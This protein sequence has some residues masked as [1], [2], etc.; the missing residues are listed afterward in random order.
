[1]ITALGTWLTHN[2]VGSDSFESKTSPPPRPV[3]HWPLY[4]SWE[5]TLTYGSVVNVQWL[6]CHEL[7]HQRRLTDASGTQHGYAERLGDAWAAGTTGL[8]GRRQRRAGTGPSRT[9][10]GAAAA[11]SAT[12]TSTDSATTAD[13]DHRVVGGRQVFRAERN[14]TNFNVIILRGD[15]IYVVRDNNQ[16]RKPFYKKK[17]TLHSNWHIWN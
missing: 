8:S 2:S 14:R 9:R 10:V 12:S 1:M 17:K 16:R 7:T 5:C 4:C 6:G 15:N 11:T 13:A 3:T